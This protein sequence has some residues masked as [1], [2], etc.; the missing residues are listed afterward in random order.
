[1]ALGVVTPVIA[2]AMTAAPTA[3]RPGAH[4]LFLSRDIDV[5]FQAGTSLAAPAGEGKQ[6]SE[7]RSVKIRTVLPVSDSEL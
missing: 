6:K 5:S 7:R 2:V 1:M 4:H 3:N